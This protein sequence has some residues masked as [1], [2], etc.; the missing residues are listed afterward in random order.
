MLPADKRYELIKWL[1]LRSHLGP[2]RREVAQVWVRTTMTY[3][4]RSACS[5]PPLPGLGHPKDAPSGCPGPVFGRRNSVESPL[6]K[7][8]RDSS[9]VGIQPGCTEAPST[10]A[11][12]QGPPPAHNPRLHAWPSQ[13]PPGAGTEPTITT[14]LE[15][16]P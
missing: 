14:Y 8:K 3:S 13:G 7:K 10:P 1:E 15:C 9:W 4:A 11:P 16:H 5:G 6:A 2:G 12:A